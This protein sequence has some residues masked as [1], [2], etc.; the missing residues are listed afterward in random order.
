VIAPIS[1]T[2]R[3]AAFRCGI[4]ALDDYFHRHALA[5]DARGISRCFVLRP[6]KPE[7]PM[8]AG[9]YTLSMATVMADAVR[10]ALPGRLPQYPLP[11]ALIGRLAVDLQA[12][13]HRFGE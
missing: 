11:V 3:A 10:H 6:G 4:H 9:Y 1:A 2:D 8:V 13:G 7:L 5:N 12:R